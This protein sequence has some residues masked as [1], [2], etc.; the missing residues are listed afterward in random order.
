[1][2]KLVVRPQWTPDDNGGWFDTINL[3]KNISKYFRSEFSK[4][5]RVSKFEAYMDS[6]VEDLRV[7]YIITF[8]DPEVVKRILHRK[9]IVDYFVEFLTFELYAIVEP[10]ETLDERSLEDDFP[11]YYYNDGV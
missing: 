11:L 6:K 5:G 3:G 10:Y 9:N 7:Y 2:N 1:M 4:Y 8:D